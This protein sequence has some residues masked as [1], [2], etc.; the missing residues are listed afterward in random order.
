[1]KDIFLGLGSSSPARLTGAG[2]LLVLSLIPVTVN[3][4]RHCERDET[5]FVILDRAT[6]AQFITDR[7]TGTILNDDCGPS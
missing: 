6:N 1:V 7:A 3:G 4:D 5:F 2:G